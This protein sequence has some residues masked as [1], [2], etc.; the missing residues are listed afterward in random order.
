LSSSFSFF[1]SVS[2][3]LF[4]QPVFQSLIGLLPHFL[5]LSGRAGEAG[6]RKELGHENTKV[7]ALASVFSTA[8]VDP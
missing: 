1:F 2:F 7:A 3:V 4:G 8:A 6:R 5:R